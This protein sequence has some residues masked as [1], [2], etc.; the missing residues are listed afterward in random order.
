MKKWLVAAVVT[1]A[2]LVAAAVWL[3]D[4]LGQVY[5]QTEEV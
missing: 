3:L 1:A 2:L 5:E 4:Q